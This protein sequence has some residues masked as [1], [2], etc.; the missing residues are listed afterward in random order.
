MA[1]KIEKNNKSAEETTFDDKNI[2]KFISS[3]YN[4]NEIISIISNLEKKSAAGSG[5]VSSRVMKYVY[6][7]VYNKP[8][9]SSN[10]CY[11]HNRY[12]TPYQ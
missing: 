1:A 10:K 11:I 5:V 6:T 4:K 8:I 3:F 9:N 2:F 7:P 12:F